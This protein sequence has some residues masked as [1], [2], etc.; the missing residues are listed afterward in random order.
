LWRVPAAIPGE[1]REVGLRCGIR[2]WWQFR[3]GDRVPRHR[4]VV[5]ELEKSEYRSTLVG[6]EDKSDMVWWGRWYS[7]TQ[8]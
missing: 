3:E 8:S 7:D 4:V 1:R 6:D 5:K 2:D